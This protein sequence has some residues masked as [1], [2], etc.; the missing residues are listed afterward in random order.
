MKSINI[1][2]V[3][4]TVQEVECVSKEELRKGEIN[5]LTNT[6]KIDGTMPKE[7]K[8]Q[9]LMHE[10]I[11]AICDLC[12]LDEIRDD[13]KTVQCLATALHQ[14]FSTQTIFF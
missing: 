6:I 12:G 14:V 9:V 13:E 3:P 2:G 4:H 7:A 10:I 11:H 5:H 1:L 8:N